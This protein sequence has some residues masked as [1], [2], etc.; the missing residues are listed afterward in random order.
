MTREQLSKIAIGTTLLGTALVMT[1]RSDTT[2]EEPEP[3]P[4]ARR[5]EV[6]A[7]EMAEATR[8]IRLAGVTRAADRAHLSFP[9]PARVASRPV[10][11]G[12]RVRA[13]QVLAALDDHEFRLA[14]QAAAAALAE[15]D[16]RL[17]QARR[18][19]SRTERLAAAEAA[20]T[21][22]LEQRRAAAS[23]L[24][25]ARDAAAARLGETRRLL[26]ES[27]LEAPFSGTITAVHIEAGE[28][29]APGQPVME[30]SGDGAVEIVVEAPESAWARLAIGLPV[31]VR[32]P[33][34]EI[35]ATGRITRLSSVSSGPGGLFPVEITLDHHSTV[36]SGLAAE[37][38]LPL[39]ATSELTVPIRSVLNPGSSRPAVFRID[40]GRA[41]RVLVE[42]GDVVGDRIVV[43]GALAAGDLI[44]VAG[45]TALAEGDAVE[46]F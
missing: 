18:E 31:D 14:E 26:A 16:I 46:V 36:V 27:T 2:T 6:S 42:I 29:A 43:D 33:F 12:D 7:V 5:I 17:A 44:A 20:T 4:P 11:V 25:A 22:E 39:E 3:T 1:A 34:L 15:F 21:E 19:A 28:W 8:T 35:D 32:L 24:S 10:E 40:D 9:I 41:E 30:L 45:H 37:I 23:A 13:G 38:S